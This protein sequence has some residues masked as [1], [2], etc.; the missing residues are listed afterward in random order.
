V[1][2]GCL[3]VVCVVCFRVEVSA[4]SRSLVQRSPTDC[5]ASSC[6]QETLWYEEARENNNMFYSNKLVFYKQHVVC[7]HF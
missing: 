4:T 6:G 7:H 3:S 5:G 1:G 2:H